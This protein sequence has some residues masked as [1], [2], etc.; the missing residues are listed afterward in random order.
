MIWCPGCVSG[1][2]GTSCGGGGRS[3]RRAVCTASRRYAFGSLSAGLAISTRL[4]KGAAT[5]E[6]WQEPSV[7]GEGKALGRAAQTVEKGRSG[8]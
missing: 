4:W 3:P 8:A 2:L 5:R 6:K 1:R 7:A